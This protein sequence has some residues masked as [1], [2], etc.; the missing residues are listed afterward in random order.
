MVNKQAAYWLTM[1]LVVPLVVSADST[2]MTL[3]PAEQYVA[4]PGQTVQHHIDVRFTGDSGTALK[5]DLTSQ[6]QET[7]T[8]NG[9]ELVFESGET[10][11]F[12]WTMTLPTSTQFGTDVLNISIIDTTDQSSE[13]ID[14]EL[15]ITTPSDIEFGNTQSST[16]IVDPGVR[17]NVATNITSNATLNDEVTFSIQTDSSW[18]WGW[19]MD[20][21]SGTNSQLELAPN[22]LDFVRIWVDVPTVV[23]GAPLANQGP[24]F[25]L[26][27]A[28]GLDGFTIAW[29]FTLEVSS[30][31]NAS[32]D[33]VQSNV[34]VDPAG[35]TRVDVLVR[36]TGNIPDTLSITLGNLVIN[37]VATIEENSDRISSNGWTAALFNAFEDV[38]LMPN[39]TRVV[40]IGVQA[41]AVTSGTVAVDLI[42]QPTNFPFR[43][44][45]ET[46]IVNVSW[47]R[48]FDHNLEPI[49]CTYLQPNATCTGLI[50]LENIGNYADSVNIGAISAPPFVTVLS[51][52]NT[53][54]GVDRYATRAFEAI[55]FQINPNATAYQQGSVDFDLQLRDGGVLQR[56]SIDV[57]VGPTVAWT[58]L[59]GLSEV[60]SRDVVSF[61]VQLRNDGNLEDGLIVQLQSSHSTEMGF[62]PPEG[63]VIEGDVQLPRTFELGNLPRDANFTLRGTA[64]LPSDQTV[65]GTLV[66][67]VVVRSI[68]DPET[69]FIYTIEENFAG[70]DWRNSQEA[71]GYSVSE[72]FE[73]V[74]LIIKGWWLIVASIAAS[75]F[76][77]N[78][79]VRDRLQRKENEALLRQIHEK[80]EETQEDWM[81]K[82]T[83]PS[84][85][86]PQVA[87]SP[88]MTSDAFTKAFQSQST[89]SAPALEPLPE[90]V[91][92]AATTV[93][94]HHDITSQKAAMD[95]IATD[96]VERGAAQPHIENLN[97]EPSK[98]ETNRTVRH[99]N[100]NLAP[101]SKVSENIP[102]PVKSNSE[103]EFDL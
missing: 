11:R 62:V 83:K 51:H 92:S 44:V 27:G 21:I 22:T 65:N 20:T 89:P 103:E 24:T 12:L 64:E 61:S 75:G 10:K 86:E 3:T 67:D 73:D 58:F 48:D 91:R 102:L 39:E 49:D 60:D 46:A 1:L 95:K 63:A 85:Q 16:F 93:L 88:T 9:Q 78:K 6:Y 94:D 2:S 84:N 45:Q 74:T 81:E 55:E 69:E 29:D 68:F 99:E 7:I 19:T 101:Q 56:Y 18:S 52:Q 53:P 37:D 79:A 40:E 90:P 97:L 59:E 50:N 5:L 31:R 32:I 4:Y 30:Y 100:P 28:S 38:V 8:G 87:V 41:P 70:K 77:L 15:K 96:I 80:P 34:V 71:D 26:I 66:L 72:F 76:I 43:T 42:L 98:A 54:F 35:N 17:T 82:F 13:Q 47:I 14:V 57:V 33:S 25:R 23:N 36:N